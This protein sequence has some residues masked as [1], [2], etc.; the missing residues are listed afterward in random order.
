MEPIARMGVCLIERTVERHFTHR[1]D[2]GPRAGSGRCGG[3][4]AGHEIDRASLCVVARTKS[5]NVSSATFSKIWRRRPPSCLRIVS[6]Q[7]SDGRDEN[8]C[9]AA[10]IVERFSQSG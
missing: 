4:L 2:A 3:L 5:I 7:D 8:S 1:G 9:S 10:A 6:T